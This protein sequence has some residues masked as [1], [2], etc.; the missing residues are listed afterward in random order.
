MTSF[1][2]PENLI[3]AVDLGTN[4]VV[5]ALKRRLPWLWTLVGSGVALHAG[6]VIEELGGHWEAVAPAAAIATEVVGHFLIHG[7]FAQRE[8][9]EHHELAERSHQLR[10]GMA[11][12]LRRGLKHASENAELTDRPTPEMFRS[13][14]YVLSQAEVDDAVLD[15][16]FPTESGDIQWDTTNPYRGDPDE[17]VCA[18][19]LLLRDLLEQDAIY[20]DWSDAQYEAFARPA[21]RYYRQ[22]FA[23]DLA[24]DA[25]GLLIQ[26]FTV[27][28]IN[29]IRAQVDRLITES[30]HLHARTHE[31]L[32]EIKEMLQPRRPA[33]LWTIPRSTEHF[34]DRPDLIAQ[35]DAA[36]EKHSTT[37]LTALHG[38]GGVGKTQLARRYAELR[39]ERYKVGVYFESENEASLLAS[40]S[41]VARMMGLPPEQDQTALALRVAI[42]ISAGEHY[43]AIFDNAVS[44][45]ALRPWVDRLSGPGH[46][47]ITS[48]DQHWDDCAQVVSVTEWSI[49][50]SSR[51]LL[52]R[53]R[54][55]D[56]V[57]AEG[58]AEDLG[59]LVLALEHAA[60]Y[61]LAGDGM[62]LADYRGVW[63]ER[64][65]RE[66]KGHPYE[67]SVAATLVLSMDAVAAQ[68]PLAYDLLSV[69]AWLAPD[70]IPRKEL[71][72]VGASSLP[73]ALAAAFADRDAWSDAVE[74]LRRYTLLRREPAQGPATGYFMHRVVQQVMRDRLATVGTAMQWVTA[75]C[76][77]VNAA[78]P[79]D[80]EIPV[81][82]WPT[83][84]A[85]LPHVRAIREYVGSADAPASFAQ[86][87]R[88][89]AGGYLR[90]RGPYTQGLDFQRWA[91]ELNLRRFGPD[92]VDVAIDRSNL[93]VFLRNLGDHR[94]ALTQI[95]LALDSVLRQFGPDDGKVA[96]LR[97]ILANTLR[98]VGDYNEARNQVEL[99]LELVLRT[100]GPD[101]LQVAV[102]R[103]GLS[104]ILIA[105][106]RYAEARDQT[107][108]S[109]DLSLRKLGP[110]H[111]NITVLRSN[112]ATSLSRL[113][114]DAE[115]REQMQM[116]LE[117]DLRQLGPD[118][119]RVAKCRSSLAMILRA[120]GEYSAARHQIELALE[121]ALKQFGPDHP[122]VASDRSNLATILGDLGEHA[123]AREQIELALEAATRQFGSEH[124]TVALRRANLSATL[125]Q[126]GDYSAALREVDLAL[127]IFRKKLPA[128][129][130]HIRFTEEQRQVIL[131]GKTAPGK[132]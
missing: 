110:D 58:L 111:Y 39:R 105:L 86:L 45:E 66:V 53:T 16:F 6:K 21:L 36:L 4:N 54:E 48:R 17:D 11:S 12:A 1:G 121:V 29:Q 120:L 31:G 19:S 50:E 95:N 73:E 88:K 3:A 23:D 114:Q 5:T 101:D 100:F 80:L 112:L 18:L 83:C 124:P 25:T 74:T 24:G 33:T 14:D 27:K 92:H 96:P 94:E 85:L 98:E 35:I 9:Q 43:L 67:H 106:G 7:A 49:A 90:L 113:G 47:L 118:H 15:R 26:S 64:L 52:E 34:Q 117:S 123:G 93:A 99:A 97:L 119:P 62:S 28:G 65:K 76:D 57:S 132:P 108:L 115:A 51:F 70:R 116:A 127:D 125:Y 131:R 79:S 8:A 63:K 37:A 102:L 68:S 30:R 13:W 104:A 38:M 77:V 130:P 69:F 84:E 40:F 122:M 128:G 61:M 87:L 103:S 44:A 82:L 20:P 60:A 32:K 2:D 55:G 46:I 126:V 42:E 72:E 129:H 10:R 22:A 81:P 78:F 59:G 107:Q 75:A 91:L 109:L 89:A 71:L 41:A 56:R